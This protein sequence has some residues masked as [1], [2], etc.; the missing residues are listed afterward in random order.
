MEEE[1]I[2]NHP[3]FFDN[4]PPNEDDQGGEEDSLSIRLE[5]ER[6]DRMKTIQELSKRIKDINFIHELQV[7]VYS[8]RQNLLERYHYLFTL[9][10]KQNAK[11]RAKKKKRFEYYANEYQ[12]N[13]TPKQRE[14]MI[15]VDLESEYDVRDELDN[16]MKYISGSMST[17][18]N[19]IFG[20][21][22][23]IDVEEYRRRM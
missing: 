14:E 22:H 18:D 12:Y 13:A 10:A 7:D 2:K 1:N 20:I 21:K 5:K 16:Q 3:L 6:T 19:I 9:L 4:P 17:I 8:E 11:I 23:R 15:R